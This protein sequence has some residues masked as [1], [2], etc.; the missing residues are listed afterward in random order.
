MFITIINDCKSQNDFGR[1]TTRLSSYFN[2]GV[3]TVGVSSSLVTKQATLEAAGNLI[4]VLDASE[5]TNGIVIVNV[6]PRGGINKK[7]ENGTPFCYFY[8]KKVL[9][10]STFEGFTLS[11]V[12]KLG[13]VEQVF[14]VDIKTVT[15]YASNKKLITQ[16]QAAYIVNT[17]FRSYEFEPRLAKW[18]SENIPLP[19]KQI[20][21]S[22]VENAPQQ[23]WYIDDFGNC[24]TTLLKKELKIVK[25]TVTTSI[26]GKLPY[27][28][29]LKDVP[30]NTIGIY[31]GSSGIGADRFIEITLQRGNL[32][33]Q[34]NLKV[35]D[36]II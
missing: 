22:E 34:K 8:Y 21:I 13:L 27:Y 2:C 15:E 17:Q 30:H 26:L 35:G 33:H 19:H 5:G 14:L 31:V 1:Q 25:G 10:I 36:K 11:L 7:W 16:D 6:A 18:L 20:P 4:D 3:N 23:I 28:N 24:K 29:R 12:K 9:I 32:A